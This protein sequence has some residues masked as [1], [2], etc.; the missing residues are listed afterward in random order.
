MYTSQDAV[1]CT[2]TSFDSILCAPSK[3]HPPA[4]WIKRENSWKISHWPGLWQT[5]GAQPGLPFPL[6][7]QADYDREGNVCQVQ[8][9]MVCVWMDQDCSTQKIKAVV[10]DVQWLLKTAACESPLVTFS[11]GGYVHYSRYTSWSLLHNWDEI[12]IHKILKI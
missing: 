11:H 5:K 2:A 1:M 4:S 3:R 6:S 7:S 8:S 12:L 9:T 10:P